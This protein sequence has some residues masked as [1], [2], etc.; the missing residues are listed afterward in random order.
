MNLY[1]FKVMRHTGEEISLSDFKGKVV[2]VVNTASKCGFTPQ[3]SGLEE[4]YKKY[5]DQGFIVIGFPCGQFAGQEFSSAEKTQEFCLI[6][7]GVSF[8]VMAKIKVNG[9]DAIPLYQWLTKAIPGPSGERIKWNFT[10]FLIDREGNPVKRFEP[11]EEPLSFA[12]DIE[13]LL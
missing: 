9:K 7:Y 4:L 5:K 3:F 8:P 12:K 11:R 10:K 6:N 1:D 13:E 2:L